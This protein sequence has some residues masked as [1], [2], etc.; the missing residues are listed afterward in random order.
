VWLKP[1]AFS[2]S[3]ASSK[4]LFDFVSAIFRI[5]AFSKKGLYFAMTAKVSTHG[6]PASG[7]V[8]LTIFVP[9]PMV[10]YFGW[11]ITRVMVLTSFWSCWR[12]PFQTRLLPNMVGGGW[13]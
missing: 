7:S 5:P 12:V 11:I 10:R 4:C 2:F 6:V 9:K 3:M 8:S 13:L 1:S